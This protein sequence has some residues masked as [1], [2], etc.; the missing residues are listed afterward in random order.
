MKLFDL[1]ELKKLCSYQ[2]VQNVSDVQFLYEF[3]SVQK[4]YILSL[5]DKFSDSDLWYSEY[6]WL[7]AYITEL[8]LQQD[9]GAQQQLFQLIEQMDWYLEEIDWKQLEL[10]DREWKNAQI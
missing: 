3:L 10:I 2:K 5:S 4:E 6:Y 8:G 7:W 1:Q 9:A